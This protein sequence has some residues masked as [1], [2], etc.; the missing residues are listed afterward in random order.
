M[1][2]SDRPV[3]EW[4]KQAFDFFAESTKQLITVATG[5]VTVTVLFSKDLDTISRYIV[6]AAWVVFVISVICGIVVLLN[7]SGN[8]QHAADGKYRYPSVTTEGI[9]LLSKIHIGTFIA[10]IVL[11]FIFGL[12]AVNGRTPPANNPIKVTCVVPPPAQPVAPER[13][14]TPKIPKHH[15]R[16]CSSTK[17]P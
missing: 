10:G 2:S 13:K 16:L 6:Y 8:L 15:L 3:H 14:V 11:L 1:P 4:R 7:L 17:T 9:A 5:V 12:F